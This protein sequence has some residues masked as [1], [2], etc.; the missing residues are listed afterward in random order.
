MTKDITLVEPITVGGKEITTVTMRKPLV[1]DMLAVEHIESQME[2]EMRILASICGLNATLEEMV[3][4]SAFAYLQ[5]QKESQSFL[6][7]SGK[8]S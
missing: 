5:L 7:G 2:R 8:S 6:P 3:K 1:E 4:W